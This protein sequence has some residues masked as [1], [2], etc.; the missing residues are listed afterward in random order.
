[1]VYLHVTRIRRKCPLETSSLG[2][3]T[4]REHLVPGPVLALGRCWSPELWASVFRV[5]EGAYRHQSCAAHTRPGRVHMLCKPW[6]RVRR[7]VSVVTGQACAASSWLDWVVGGS[8]GGP[9]GYAK[10]PRDRIPAAVGRPHAQQASER[11]VFAFLGHD[12]DSR[13]TGEFEDSPSSAPPS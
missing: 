11:P 12:C 2:W 9:A 4:P 10:W 8:A 7:D 1:M 13:P 3:E 5:C 6:S